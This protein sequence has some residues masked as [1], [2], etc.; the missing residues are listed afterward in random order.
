V[1]EN[2]PNGVVT[3]AVDDT[4][5]DNEACSIGMVFDYPAWRANGSLGRSCT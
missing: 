1:F 2:P 3:G 5:W 4:N